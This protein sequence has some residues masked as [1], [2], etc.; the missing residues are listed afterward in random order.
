MAG[1]I[2]P[3][4]PVGSKGS[5]TWGG[6]IPER[7]LPPTPAGPL[8]NLPPRGRGSFLH[9]PQPLP[10]NLH[11][12]VVE[13]PW[14]RG[15]KGLAP[16][17]ARCVLG[18]AARLSTPHPTPSSWLVFDE[19]SGLT[20]SGVKQGERESGGKKRGGEREGGKWEGEGR[21]SGFGKGP[22]PPSLHPSEP[23]GSVFASPT[24][25]RGSLSGPGAPLCGEGSCVGRASICDYLR[26][27]RIG[28]M[29]SAFSRALGHRSLCS[30]F[31]R[32]E[33]TVGRASEWRCPPS[34][35]DAL[36]DLPGCVPSPLPNPAPLPWPV[37]RFLPRRQ[38]N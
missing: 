6:V 34:Q 2:A 35:D 10:P 31:L 8:L 7:P 11:T 4:A 5:R 16:W 26:L 27:A 9:H 23:R 24:C 25:R 19:V 30:N 38:S 36:R 3:K 22:S 14:L 12:R 28:W 1:L 13:V 29:R 21:G 32:H 37:H 20:G 15:H 17:S 18:G 33:V